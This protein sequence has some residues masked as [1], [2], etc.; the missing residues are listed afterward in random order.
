MGISSLAKLVCV[1]VVPV[2]EHVCDGG[3]GGGQ[4]SLSVPGCQRDA[5]RMRLL[6]HLP[7][8]GTAA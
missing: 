7:D 6:L 8:N 5:K 3:G 1:I 2:G 4:G